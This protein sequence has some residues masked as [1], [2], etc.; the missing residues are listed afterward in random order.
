MDGR[1]KYTIQMWLETATRGIRF[2]PDRAA[3]ERELREH[4]EDKTADLQRI[5]PDMTTEEAQDRALSTMG[6]AEEIGKE[7]AKIHKPWLGYLWRAS[8]AVLILV[9]VVSVFR[10]G[11]RAVERVQDWW[12]YERQGPGYEEYVKECYYNGVDPF[13]PDS[14]WYDENNVTEIVRTPLGVWR[15]E[16]AARA[17]GYR[18]RIEQAALWSFQGGSDPEEYWWLF[19][20]LRADSL[21]WEH[22]SLEAAWHIRAVDSFGNQYYDSFQVYELREDRGEAGYVM[23]NHEDS[24]L[25]YENFDLKIIDIAPGAEWIRLEFDRGGPAWSLTIPLT[26][27]AI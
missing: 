25:L 9:L 6:D 10:W 5:F 16:D 7:L 15:P 24:G 26:E 22:F 8:R 4:I 12:Q 18:F 23:V 13:G 17:G 19:C 11:G 3:A 27:D 21:P 14:P 1:E 2:G 20:E